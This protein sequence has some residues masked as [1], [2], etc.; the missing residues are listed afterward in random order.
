MLN[1][2]LNEAD[3]STI[4]GRVQ[5][6][7]DPELAG[8]IEKILYSHDTTN[9]QTLACLAYFQNLGTSTF[10]AQPENK[11][12]ALDVLTQYLLSDRCKHENLKYV[13]DA[14]SHLCPLTEYLQQ[15][16][17]VDA[18]HAHSLSIKNLLN[19]RRKTCQT[20]KP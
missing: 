12:K 15:L 17:F 7:G 4:I 20:L 11:E 19:E 16:A 5:V 8:F 9:E 10:H 2:S 6:F 14:I 3:I 1:L 18:R 13:F